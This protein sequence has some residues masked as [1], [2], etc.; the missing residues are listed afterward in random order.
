MDDITQEL[1][2]LHL[3]VGQL[4]ES[5]KIR[6]DANGG[7]NYQQAKLWLEVCDQFSQKN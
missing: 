3:L 7:L 5:G 1:E 6:L 2:I 4:P